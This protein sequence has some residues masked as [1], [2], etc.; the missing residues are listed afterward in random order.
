MN[1]KIVCFDVDGTLTDIKSSWNELTRGMGLPVEKIYDV[2]RKTESGR[3]SFAAGEKILKDIYLANTNANRE[4]IA[5]LFENM[6]LR[7]DA[8]ELVDDLKSRGYLVYLVSGGIRMYV[9]M[10][11]K[12]LK[13]DGFFAHSSFKFDERGALCDIDFST[14]GNQRRMKVD[15]I[16][17]LSKEH[18]VPVNEIFFAGD[19]END[20][21]VFKL[22]GKGIAVE[23]FTEILR[24]VAWK[25]VAKLAEIRDIL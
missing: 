4:F 9:E 15:L 18:G 2:Y 8:R 1:K 3:I 21:E 24:P 25:T 17:K 5:G 11:A 16:Y 13:P 22:T 7:K 20:L 23:P 14:A 19:S 10:I 6:P 12:Q